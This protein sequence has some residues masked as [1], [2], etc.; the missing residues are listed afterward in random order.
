MPSFDVV[1][2]VDRMEVKNALD[3]A[4]RELASRFDFKGVAAEISLDS[5]TGSIHLSCQ[6]AARLKALREIVAGRL[7]KRG[8]D[9]RNIEEK[10][11]EISPLGHARQELAVRQGIAGPEAKAISQAV[12]ALGLK[13]Q[14]TLQDGQVRVSGAKKDDLQKVIAAL[15]S[16]DFGIA[17]GFKNFRD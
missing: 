5:K 1:S 7:A 17:L 10:P 16:S 6:D 15:K 9:L 13:V 12:K 2:E 8:V 11:P 4:Q 3:Q 14:S